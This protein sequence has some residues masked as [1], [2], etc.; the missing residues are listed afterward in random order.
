VSPDTVEH[1]PIS[2]VMISGIIARIVRLEKA[3]REPAAE[4]PI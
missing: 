2:E 1:G 3:F 4:V